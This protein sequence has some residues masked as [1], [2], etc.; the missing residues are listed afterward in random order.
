MLKDFINEVAGGIISALF[1]KLLILISI[2]F[3]LFVGGCVG[4]NLAID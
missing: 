4:I 2:I 3:V 1:T